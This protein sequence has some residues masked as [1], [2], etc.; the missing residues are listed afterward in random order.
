[1]AAHQTFSGGGPQ[2]QSAH[3]TAGEGAARPGARHTL[4]ESTPSPARAS[5][6]TPVT[7]LPGQVRHC[8]SSPRPRKTALQ[9]PRARAV[10][11][12]AAPNAELHSLTRK[13]GWGER[14]GETQPEQGGARLKAGTWD[15]FLLWVSVKEI[16]AAEGRTATTAPRGT[17]DA[18]QN[19]E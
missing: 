9:V 15:R 12:A 6:Q 16:M 17:Q 18:K 11:Q 13:R 14:Q 8:T 2:E 1:M 10:S 4:G 7:L 19:Q 3:L 5:P